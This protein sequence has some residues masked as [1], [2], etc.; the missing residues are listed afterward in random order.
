MVPFLAIGAFAGLRS[1]EIQRLDWADLKE[2]FIE[3]TAGNAK[4]RSRRLVPIQ[5]NLAK[6]LAIYRQDS[7]LERIK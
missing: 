4:T 7:G 1:A 3:V 2:S 5:P 6:W